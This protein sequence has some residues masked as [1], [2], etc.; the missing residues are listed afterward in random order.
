VSSR[1]I[2][3]GVAYATSILIASSAAIGILNPAVAAGLR[4][5][6]LTTYVLGPV[7]GAIIGVALYTVLFADTS[8]TEVVELETVT[9][10]TTSKRSATT[11]AKAT[12]AKRATAKKAAPK[13]RTTSRKR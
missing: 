7:I 1:A 2:F 8:V 13:R 3:T 9:V 10:A 4:A 12:T 11:R 5:W 6:V